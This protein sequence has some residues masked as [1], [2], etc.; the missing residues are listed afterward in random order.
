MIVGGSGGIV[1]TLHLSCARPH[2]RAVRRPPGRCRVTVA[3]MSQPAWRNR[4]ELWS[5]GWSKA[6]V[7]NEIRRGRAE[8]PV[9]GVLLPAG[10]ANSL[11]Q[12]CGAALST[13]HP[14][15]AITRRTAAIAHNFAWIPD[16]WRSSRDLCVDAPREDLTRSSRLGLDRRLSALP[17]EDVTLWDGLRIATEA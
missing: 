12:R 16:G 6:V 13:Q 15:A 9:R 11:W 2:A 5:A 10:A 7:D 17:P 1:H 4:G 3:P 14:S 8:S